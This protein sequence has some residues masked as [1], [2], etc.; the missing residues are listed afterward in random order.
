MSLGER[1][2][3]DVC[4]PDRFLTDDIRLISISQNIFLALF[5]GLLTRHDAQKAH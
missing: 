5:G 2:C 4:H 1:R 3:C